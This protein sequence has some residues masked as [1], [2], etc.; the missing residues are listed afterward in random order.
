LRAVRA[1]R[2]AKFVGTEPLV[3]RKRLQIL[4]HK[5]EVIRFE[6]ELVRA[7]PKCARNTDNNGRSAEMLQNRAA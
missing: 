7:T 5:L 3:I 1:L 6:Y 4:A 2:I